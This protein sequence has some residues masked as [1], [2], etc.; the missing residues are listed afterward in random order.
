[1]T[2][3]HTLQQSLR[4]INGENIITIVAENQRGG[5]VR[6]SRSVLVGNDNIVNAVDVNRK[7]YALIFATDSYENWD[8]LINPVS[9]ARMIESV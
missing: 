7:D 3:S 4:L 5:R 9:D 1:M 6:S 2:L 8:D